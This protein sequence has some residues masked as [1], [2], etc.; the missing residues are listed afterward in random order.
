MGDPKDEHQGPNIQFN[1]H[2]VTF[3]C[4]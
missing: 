1:G 4:R 2:E 3:T